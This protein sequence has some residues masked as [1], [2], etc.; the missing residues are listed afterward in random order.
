MTKD[1]EAERRLLVADLVDACGVLVPILFRSDELSPGQKMPL[2]R[3]GLAACCAED[4]ARDGVI[5]RVRDLVGRIGEIDAQRIQARRW[6]EVLGIDF[7][8]LKKY[9]V[10]LDVN[11]VKQMYALRLSEICVTLEKAWNHPRA[12]ELNRAHDEAMAEMEGRFPR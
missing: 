6:W 11:L 8:R 12:A 7:E 5:D 3:G 2:R 4:R 10:E 9:G 1:Q